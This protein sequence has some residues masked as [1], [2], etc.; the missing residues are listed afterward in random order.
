M[1]PSLY[2]L[3]GLGISV[4]GVWIRVG[5]PPIQTAWLTRAANSEP[6]HILAHTALYGA[7]T[8][9]ALVRLSPAR[10]VAATLLL[11]LIQELAQ[12]VGV[13]AFGAGEIYDLA[14]DGLAAGL[15][16]LGAAMA[17]HRG[18]T[19]PAERTTCLTSTP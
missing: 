6:V 4:G 19:A 10:A 13:R 8:A 9:L 18:R 14:V 7:C 5:H 1:R 12:V 16:G 3:W 17:L 11:G 15:V 2:I